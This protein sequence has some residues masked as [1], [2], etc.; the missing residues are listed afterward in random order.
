MKHFQ[1]YT[2]ENAPAPADETLKSLKGM[3][4]FVPNVFAVMA[5]TPPVLAA[6]ATLNEKFAET[7]LS[8]TEREIVQIAVSV[9]NGCTYCVAGHTAFAK[10]QNV[11]D[12]II[13]AVRDRGVLDDPK[14][15]A[16]HD[17]ARAVLTKMGNIEDAELE[18]FLSAGYTAAQVQEVIVGVC[19]KVFSNLTSNLLGIPLDEAF[20]EYAWEAAPARKVA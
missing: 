5:G 3:L 11:P 14:L 13:T 7:S 8:P 15:A 4:G 2:P 10:M 16:L 18:R 6:F 20:A 17:F 12:D 1:I 9:E 19:T